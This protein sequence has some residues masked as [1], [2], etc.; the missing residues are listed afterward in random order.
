MYSV[1][2]YVQVI[3]QKHSFMNTFPDELEMKIIMVE[4]CNSKSSLFNSGIRIVNNYC[5]AWYFVSVDAACDHLNESCGVA[6]LSGTDC[7]AAQG[8]PNFGIWGWNQSVWP[9]KWTPMS[10]SF[11]W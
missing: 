1:W 5:S 8:G 7:C 4:W 10:H 9:L 2:C 11:I 3:S 6:L